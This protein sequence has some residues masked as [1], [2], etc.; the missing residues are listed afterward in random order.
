MNYYTNGKEINLDGR[1]VRF[2]FPIRDTLTIDDTII[3]LLHIP[4][5]IKCNRNLYAINLQGTI[6]WQIDE[7]ADLDLIGNCPFISIKK[8][9]SSLIIFN[10]CGFRYTVDPKSGKIIEKVFTK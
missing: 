7:V 9:E 2:D 10:W 3:I 1:S 6:L 8:Q 5:G 4:T